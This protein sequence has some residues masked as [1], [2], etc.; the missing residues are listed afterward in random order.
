MDFDIENISIGVTV[1]EICNCQDL[2]INLTKCLFGTFLCFQKQNRED[3]WNSLEKTITFDMEHFGIGET[4]LEL[5]F[6]AKF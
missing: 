1:F 3:I 6:F 5:G 2:M 4:K